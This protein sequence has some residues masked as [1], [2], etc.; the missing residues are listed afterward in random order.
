MPTTTA[1]ANLRYGVHSKAAFVRA[2]FGLQ[3]DEWTDERMSVELRKRDW[4][5]DRLI[6]DWLRVGPPH[7]NIRAP[8]ELSEEDEAE[9]A[10]PK[11]SR[12]REP[13]PEELPPSFQRGSTVGEA[14]ATE[15]ALGVGNSTVI[16]QILA[17][18]AQLD[19][20]ELSLSE[21]GAVATG[22]LNKIPKALREYDETVAVRQRQ[23]AQ[24]TGSTGLSA[25]IQLAVTMSDL[26]RLEGWTYNSSENI[27]ICNDCFRYSTSP[28]VPTTL[29]YAHGSGVIQGP[30]SQRP[31]AMVKVWFKKHCFSSIHDWCCTHACEVRLRTNPNPNPNPHTHHPHST[32]APPTPKPTPTHTPPT[33]HP[34]L[35]SNLHRSPSL[36]SHRFAALRK[37]TPRPVSTVQ[38]SC[39]ASSRSTTQMRATS[40]ASPASSPWGL[41]WAP[42][43]TGASLC[44][45][46]GSP[47]MILSSAV[48]PRC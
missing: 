21:G 17:L 31:L 30:N 22:V 44:L 47:C 14:A 1:A 15:T 26:G 41:T 38:S 24:E 23:E 35:D 20:L 36:S 29:K 39:L 12:L 3:E 5:V 2:T 33:H 11:R 10:S 45:S 27:L 13:L 8:A 25:R 43:T 4:N 7:V 42:K 32:H 34:N 37:S 6:D 19:R 9:D 40:G 48:S 16:N 46:F 28:Q 18:K